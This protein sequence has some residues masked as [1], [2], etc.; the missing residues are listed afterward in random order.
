MKSFISVNS[1]DAVISYMIGNAI[2]KEHA[3]VQHNYPAGNLIS[4]L[5]I[6]R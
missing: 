5:H 2:S 4:A 6:V 3:I 1:R